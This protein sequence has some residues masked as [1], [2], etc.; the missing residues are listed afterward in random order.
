[1]SRKTYKSINGSVEKQKGDI[2]SMYA[3]HQLD[4]VY[5]CHIQ[6]NQT[7][8]NY[9]YF[10]LVLFVECERQGLTRFK[11]RREFET[12][13]TI[14]HQNIISVKTTAPA[15]I[16]NIRIQDLHQII[17]QIQEEKCRSDTT[18]DMLIRIYMYGDEPGMQFA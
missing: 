14:M 4:G 16:C 1:M 8:L 11:P 3:S 7:K 9:V 6:R 12:K 10:H 17:L 2:H 5:Y 15:V 18:A 13:G